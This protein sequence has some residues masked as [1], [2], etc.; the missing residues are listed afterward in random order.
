[1]FAHFK[2]VPCNI[3]TPVRAKGCRPYAEGFQYQLSAGSVGSFVAQLSTPKYVVSPYIFLA[4]LMQPKA[5]EH[6]SSGR[7]YYATDR[8]G[9]VPDKGASQ[10]HT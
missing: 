9:A 3:H 2:R 5:R 7:S 8:P 1:M 10:V 4:W 6:L